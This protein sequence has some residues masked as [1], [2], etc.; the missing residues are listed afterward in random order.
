MII[1]TSQRL[2]C[3][4]DIKYMY[5]NDSELSDLLEHGYL[6]VTVKSTLR[7]DLKCFK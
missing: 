2:R 6:G 1:G 3:V 4:S 7:W 5:I